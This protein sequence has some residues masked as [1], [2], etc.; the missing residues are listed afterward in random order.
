MKF[1]S[2]A[3]VGGSRDRLTD[4][5]TELTR[6]PQRVTLLGSTGSIGTQAM[7]VIDHLAALKGTSASA[8]D[9]P[10]K[11]V[12]LSAG[13]RSLE[14]LARQ[15]VHVRA[16]LVAT[17]GT[18]EDA[19]RLRELI[20]AAASEAGATGYT[21]QIAHGAEA[22]VQAAAHPAD[23][24][25]NGITGSIGLEPTLTALNSGYRVALANKESLI[26]GGP[27]VRAAV[28]AS[29]LDTPMVPVDSEHSALAQALASGTDAEIDRLIL[30]A[31]G[32]PFRGYKREQL[33]DVTP[34]Q[35]LAHPT[36]DMGL[37][38]TTNSATMVNKALEV[39][40][41]HH[42]FG[43]DLDR[44]DVAVHPQSVVHSMVQFVDGST[45]AQASPPS[46][47]LPIALGLT[48]PH[49][50]PGAVPACDWSKAA[51]WTFEPLDEEAFPA[52]RM[53]KDAGKIGGTHPAVFNAANE[54]AVAAFHAGAIRFTDIVDSVARVLEEHTGSAE[55]VS[56]AD[57]TLE[58]VLNAERW[59]RVRANELL[60]MT[61]R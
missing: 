32:G 43:V 16:E 8:A 13:S 35:A 3:R 17:S 60:G 24:V 61:G 4:A 59:A 26:A 27:L 33:H 45:I 38:V 54:E 28:D 53:I 20:E 21:P 52:V 22:S 41:A 44:I 55:A 30:T 5:L 39:L 50:I 47:V 29:P 42:L 25:L 46:M 11:V 57:L 7:E 19:Q 48:W 10:L 49:R 9:A 36:W 56:D 37:V 34:A 51:S 15:A 40:E 14:L 31:S 6:A 18:A 23:T 2:S 1:G 12:A 58:A